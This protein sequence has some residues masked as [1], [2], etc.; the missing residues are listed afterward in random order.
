MLEIR[1]HPSTLTSEERIALITFL[2]GG[3][4]VSLPA[5]AGP[6]EH[7]A[8]VATFGAEAPAAPF[9]PAA[10]FT[11]GADLSAIV[12]AAP[13][14]GVPAPVSAA[15]Q[16]PTPGT[17][18][19]APAPGVELD[20]NGLP[21]DGRIHGSTRAKNADGS[22][23]QKRNTPPDLVANVEAELRAAMGVP[24]PVPAAGTVPAAPTA[25]PAP[26]PAAP[27]TGAPAAPPA[28]AGGTTAA[29]P[30]SPT[31]FPEFLLRVTA[32]VGKG[33]FS[34]ADVIAACQAIGV[35][36]LPALGARVDLIPSVC[37]QLGI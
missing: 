31:T 34:Q 25:A 35:P 4:L 17:A 37:M 28:P 24:A 5:L 1:F 10:P 15:Q 9:V 21:W 3:P 2:G 13:P 27:E 8:E 29:S 36:S 30:S 23:R 32:E 12:P 26:V 22:W 6:S 33:T 14:G 18:T 19:G 16:S 11:A 7:K 20:K